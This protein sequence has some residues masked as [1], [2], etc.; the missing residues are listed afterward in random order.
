MEDRVN[1]SELKLPFSESKQKA[2]LGYLLINEKFFRRAKDRI[3]PNWFAHARCEQIFD[4][5]VRESKKAGRKLTVDEL[6]DSHLVINLNTHDG[7]AFRS[8]ARMCMNFT[9][10]YG[11]DI[12]TPD[13]T[14]WLR[15]QLYIQEVEKSAILFN[16]RKEGKDYEAKQAEAYRI[17]KAMSQNIDKITFDPGEEENFDNLQGDMDDLEY[18]IENALSFGL[19]AMDRLLQPDLPPI[20]DKLSA[21]ERDKRAQ[22]QLEAGSLLRGDATVLLSPTNIGKTTSMITVASHNL[23]QGKNVLIITHEGR[24]A[25]IKLKIRQCCTGLTR[26]DLFLLRCDPKM[27]D[28]FEELAALY[29]RHLVYIPINKAGL[30]IEDVAARIERA[31]DEFG[32]K[33]GEKFDLIV[34]DYLAKLHTVQNAKGHLERR[35]MDEII[36]NYAVQI[37]LDKEAH[38]LT[39]IQTNRDGSKVNRRGKGQE[40]RLLTLEDVSESWGPMTSATNVISLNRDPIAK[41]RGRLTY[42]ICKSRSSETDWAVVCKSNFAACQTHHNDLGATWYRGTSTM[43]ERIDELFKN[44]INVA[45]PDEYTLGKPG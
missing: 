42:Y 40:D 30:T 31:F 18:E 10:K 4:L 20:S 16:S 23:K 9:S 28:A 11:L 14:D 2:L 29:R 41:A 22:A 3:K 36:Y 17:I 8:M 15:T 21:A 6:F 34:D 13:L 37:A 33:T 1:D 26:R 12:L 44:H 38:F 19:K 7:E 45:I 43:T 24:P 25:D 5:L 39:A 35:Q 32:T 27:R